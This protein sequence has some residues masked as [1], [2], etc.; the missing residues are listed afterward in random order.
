MGMIKNDASERF[1]QRGD[2]DFSC[3]GMGGQEKREERRGQGRGEGE[4]ERKSRERRE[5]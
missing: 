5:K 3:V 4:R 1:W 2:L